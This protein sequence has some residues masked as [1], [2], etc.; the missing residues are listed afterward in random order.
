MVYLDTSVVARVFLWGFFAVTS[1]YSWGGG[2]VVGVFVVGFVFV[3]FVYLRG[4]RSACMVYVCFCGFS[5]F[6]LFC[7]VVLFF[8]VLLSTRCLR[9]M[10]VDGF[11]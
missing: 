3:R 10:S 8:G 6:F 11:G 2:V 5:F 1:G 4:V 7:G 9:F